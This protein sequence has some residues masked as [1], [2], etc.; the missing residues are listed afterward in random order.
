MICEPYSLGARESEEQQLG[1]LMVVVG[2]LVDVRQ[3][4]RPQSVSAS[5]PGH[6]LE[7]ILSLSHQA[8][9]GSDQL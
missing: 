2:R 4:T 5:R 1:M 7:L 6:T 8:P 3:V 9:V